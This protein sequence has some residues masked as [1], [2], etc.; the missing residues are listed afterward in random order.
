MALRQAAQPMA[1]DFAPA[2]VVVALLSGLSA[3]LFLRLPPNAGHE[4][5]GH[6]GTRPNGGGDQRG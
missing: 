5:S 4:I 6:T 1:S 2:F 3:L